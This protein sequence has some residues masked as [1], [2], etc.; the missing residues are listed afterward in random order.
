MEAVVPLALYGVLPLAR[1]AGQ[2]VARCNGR[3]IGRS[4]AGTSNTSRTIVLPLTVQSASES[5]GRAASIAWQVSAGKPKVVDRS[6]VLLLSVSV[7]LGCLSPLQFAWQL[8]QRRKKQE[9]AREAAATADQTAG[10][11]APLTAAEGAAGTMDFYSIVDYRLNYVAGICQNSAFMLLFAYNAYGPN[12][13]YMF[14]FD[15]FSAQQK[16]RGLLFAAVALASAALQTAV[17]FSAE[18]CLY[19]RHVLEEANHFSR[20]V[21]RHNFWL[22]LWLLMQTTLISGACMIMKHDGMDLSF[23]FEGCARLPGLP[24]LP[25]ARLL[26]LIP[27]A[28]CKLLPP[29]TV[30]ARALHC[31]VATDWNW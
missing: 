4:I 25:P 10:D 15:R 5:A 27:T 2:S 3:S 6:F 23:R 28:C 1:A 9:R 7:V 17:A 20:F 16:R 30:H 22:I 14:G 29:T 19:G 13:R 21:L 26:A 8:R 11:E 18:R 24:R 12:G 31:V